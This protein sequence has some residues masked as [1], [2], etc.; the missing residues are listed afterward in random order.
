MSLSMGKTP[1]NSTHFPRQ[2]VVVLSADSDTRV[3]QVYP[4]RVVQP[5]WRATVSPLAG[6]PAGQRLS[7]L[8]KADAIARLLITRWCPSCSE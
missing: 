8:A 7:S 3:R 6:S 4:L 5:P 1:A 2:P